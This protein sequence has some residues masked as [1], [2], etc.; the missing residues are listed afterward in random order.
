MRFLGFVL[1]WVFS[2][3][4]IY[5]Q[6][7]W[8]HCTSIY[9]IYPR[10]FYDT[11][12]DGIGDIPGIIQKLDYIRQLGFETIWISPFF[13]SPQRDFGYDV[14]DYRSIAPEYGTTEDAERLI[15]EAHAR[16]MRVIFDLVMNHTSI[17]HPWFTEDVKRK[18]EDRNVINDYY[19]W[20]DKPNNW[21]SMVRGSAWHYHPERAQYYYAAFLPFQPDLNYRNPAVKAAMLENVRFWLRKGVDGFRLDIFN[22]IY[23]DSLLRDNPRSLNILTQFRRP[24][25]TANLPECLQF[26]EE[27]RAVCDSFGEKLL[28]GEIIGERSTSRKYCGDTVNNRLTLAFNFEMLRFRFRARYFERLIRNMERDFAAPFMPVYV[29]S[30]HDRRRMMSRV[31]GNVNKAKLIHAVQFLARGVPCVY[32][33]EEIGMQ[34]GHLPHKNSLDPIPK[35]VKLPRCIF[36]LLNET[37]NRDDVR[38]PMQW[39][40]TKNAGFSACEKTWL[41]VHK[42]YRHTNV[43][44]CMRDT[45]S[46]YHFIRQLHL[47]RPDTTQ[48]K[49]KRNVLYLNGAILN[50]NKIRH[51]REVFTADE[52]VRLYNS[53]CAPRTAPVKGKEHLY[54]VWL[55]PLS[56]TWVK[57]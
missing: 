57:R 26:A 5:A 43:A 23:E 40:S 44:K 6:K 20:R 31:K 46:L 42:D 2:R 22:S 14:S 29:F 9:Q 51:I 41:P 48:I 32:Y 30:N 54:N 34:D 25:Y 52:A 3:S 35:Y 12:G 49:R 36:Q 45:S 10:S 8:Y 21:R 17:E 37:L 28:I 33:G 38:T 7:P 16:G 24:V 50:F 39:D 1:L 11:N 47:I 55:P 18:P 13:K 15:R 19:V 56:V 27:L 4:V 53:R